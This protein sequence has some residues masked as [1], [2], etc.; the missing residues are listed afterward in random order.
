MLDVISRPDKRDFTALKPEK[1]SYLSRLEQT[2]SSIKI[3]LITNLGFGIAPDDEVVHAVRRAAKMFEKAGA[4]IEEI[5][6]PIFDPHAADCAERF[7]RART[8]TELN[9]APADRQP[10][11]SL[12]YDWTRAT[13]RESAE[14]L[15]KAINEMTSLRERTLRLS[16]DVDFLL[17]PSTPTTAFAAELPAPP[18]K[19]IFDPWCN[20]FLFNL[21]EQPGISLNCGLS[22]EGL[23]IGLQIIG[24]RYDDL[25]VLRMGRLFECLFELSQPEPARPPIL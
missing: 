4:S 11:T 22:S 13:Q 12:M 14:D 15:F 19:G 20:T 1:Q 9:A 10:R 21:T 17:L 16:D 25:G 23:P 24:K 18:G 7:Y 8:Y 6:E 5:S 3:R 2:P